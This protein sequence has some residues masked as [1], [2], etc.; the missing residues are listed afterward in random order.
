MK[1]TPLRQKIRA[2]STMLFMLFFPVI[3]YYLS[4]VIPLQ[5][6]T[7]G[8]V[9][10][11]LIIFS[12]L[13]L[14]SLFLGRGFC[15]YI[16]PAGTIQDHVMTANNRSFPRRKMG[17]LKFLLWGIWLG[18]LFFLFRLAGGIQGFDFT[19]ATKNGISVSDV[20]SLIIYLIVVSV[21]FFIA[22][23]AGRRAACHT[24]CWMAPFMILGQRLGK[25]LRTPSLRVSSRTSECIECGRCTAVCP[26]S[27]NVQKLQ[28][29]GFV[30]SVDCI[31]CGNCIDNCPK[32]ILSFK[33][34]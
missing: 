21:F 10:G 30:D 29:K 33:W 7:I 6:G 31:L 32:K 25:M 26:M 5:A 17:W 11:S 15:S 23:S 9:S 4:P 28:Q 3:F 20:Q 2:A 18:L 27:I 16:C 12:V 8:I 1:K 24:L 13:F 34:R 22:L 19:F 14:A